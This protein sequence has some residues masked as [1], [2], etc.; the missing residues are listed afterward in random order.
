MTTTAALAAFGI[1]GCATGP[2]TRAQVCTQFDELG[3]K[4]L[5]ANGLFDNPVFSEA[6]DLA[7]T[8]RRYPG[9][10]DLGGDAGALDDIANSD[11]T[12]GMAIENATTHIAAL[13]GHPL[14]FGTTDYGTGNSSGSYLGDSGNSGGD[15][16]QTQQAAP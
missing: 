12:S 11:S 14:G 7:D 10:P 3:Q 8:A 9:T 4:V 2:T 15:D 5:A 1:A 16:Y 6:G 13:C